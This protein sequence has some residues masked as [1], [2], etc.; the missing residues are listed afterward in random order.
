MHFFFFT[1]FNL[2]LIYTVE[3]KRYLV[4]FSRTLIHMHVFC[5]SLFELSITRNLH[6]NSV[7]GNRCEVTQSLW[8]KTME[9]TLSS[10]Y[11][12]NLLSFT[13]KKSLKTFNARV[14]YS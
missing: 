11:T 5:L 3:V 14:Q 6:S 7:Y 10:Q 12:G 2:T 1:V 8:K 13:N 9:K 4:I